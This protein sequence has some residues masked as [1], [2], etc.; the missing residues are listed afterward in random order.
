MNGK[1][2]IATKLFK[3]LVNG[4][5][6]FTTVGSGVAIVTTWILYSKEILVEPGFLVWVGIVITGAGLGLIV[7]SV[8]AYLDKKI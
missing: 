1:K 7:D 2:T 5:L 4:K 6:S 3:R 8:Q